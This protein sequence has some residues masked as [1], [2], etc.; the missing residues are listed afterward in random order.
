MKASL[1]LYEFI[2]KSEGL[3]LTAYKCEAGVYTIGF[4][5]TLTTRAGD[6]ITL[7]EA[8]EYLIED[9]EHIERLLNVYSFDLSQNEFDALISLI[10]NIG[11]GAFKNST[12]FIKLL[13]GQ[14]KSE[15]A[16][17]F[18]RW[19]YVNQKI[20][21]GLVIRRDREV[22]MFLFGQYD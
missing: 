21:N 6:H 16:K 5:H 17:E 14:R 12:L 9:I 10:Y 4:G 22:K 3:K 2:Q 7:S 20:S 15:I 8:N 13:Q 19:I 18:R 11:S 1:K